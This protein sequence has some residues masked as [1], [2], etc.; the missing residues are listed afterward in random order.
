VKLTLII[1]FVMFFGFRIGS[2]ILATLTVSTVMLFPESESASQPLLAAFTNLEDDFNVVKHAEAN[3]IDVWRKFQ[4]LL[5]EEFATITF[6]KVAQ[7]DMDLLFKKIKNMATPIVKQVLTYGAKNLSS[8]SEYELYLMSSMIEST[9]GMVKKKSIAYKFLSKLNHKLDGL[10]KTPYE[11]VRGLGSEKVPEKDLKIFSWNTCM[12]PGKLS[13]VISGL[14]PWKER[15]LQITS[16]IK[17]QDADVI[18]LQEV[19]SEIGADFLYEKL[20]DSYAHF[21]MNMGPKMMGSK[22]EDVGLNSGLFVASKVPL[23]DLHFE[24]FKSQEGQKLVNKGFFWAKVKD[25]DIGFVTCHLEPFNQEHS[26]NVRH[27]ELGYLVNFLS[28]KSTAIRFLA[29]DL[30][31]PWGSGE[32]AETLIRAHFFDPYN[33]NRC[34]V[35]RY[36]RTFSD[37]FMTKKGIGSFDILDYFLIYQVKGFE[38]Y[39]FITERVEGFDEISLTTK[40]SDH[41]GLLSQIVFPHQK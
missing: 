25:S 26:F 29:G 6:E 20:K 38:K 19:H 34:D 15:I 36:S 24:A 31:I 2:I 30:N 37:I 39:A 28:S 17:A 18:C 3:S 33:K 1:Y 41:H 23:E 27:E 9:L 40:G 32:K 10:H 13:Q 5:M 12:L 22:I 35:S 21:Y 11:Y 14:D 16:T 4:A 8:L 7:E